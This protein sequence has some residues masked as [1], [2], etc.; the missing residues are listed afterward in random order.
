MYSNTN[1]NTL[2]MYSSAFWIRMITFSMKIGVHSTEFRISCEADKK[3]MNQSDQEPIQ[4]IP[5]PALNTKRERD[6]Y[7]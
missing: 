4:R 6:T 1:T 2:Q 7:N 5:H 3:A